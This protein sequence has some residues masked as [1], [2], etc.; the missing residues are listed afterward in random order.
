[1]NKS[2]PNS[3]QTWSI[4]KFWKPASAERLM[5]LQASCGLLADTPVLP[6]SFVR[7]A[8]FVFINYKITPAWTML[9]PCRRNGRAPRGRCVQTCAPESLLSLCCGILPRLPLPAAPL[10]RCCGRLGIGCLYFLSVSLLYPIWAG[11]SIDVLPEFCIA[12]C[13]KRRNKRNKLK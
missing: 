7:E 9:P 8:P 11:F 3:L 10:L 1:M 12:L 6:Y 4:W 2:F 13:D 5:I